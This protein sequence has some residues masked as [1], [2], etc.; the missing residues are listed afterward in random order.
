MAAVVDFVSDVVEGAVDA[1]G[2][3]VEGV[4]DVIEDVGD[5]I[6]DAGS[7]IDD[8]VLQPALDD[9]LKTVATI[10]AVA[11]GQ[12]HLI[13]YINAASVAIKGGDLEDIGKAY[14]ISTVAQGAG[15]FVAAEA[16]QMAAGVEY[17]V[18]AGS[19]QAAMLAAQEAGMNTAIDF[20]AT[21]GGSA[22]GAAAGAALSGGDPVTA[23]LLGGTS[24]AIGG[25]V[26]YGAEEVLGTDIAQ[27][28]LGKIGTNVASSAAKA[29]IMPEVA[30][31]LID[32]PNRGLTQIA[33]S[34]GISGRPASTTGGS[35]AG[36]YEMKK[37]INDEGG[38]IYVSFKDGEPQQAIPPGYREEK[39]GEMNIA[40]TT[41]PK[42]E[43]TAP[44]DMAA[45]KGG[46][47]S[48]KRKPVVKSDKG[49]AKR[50]K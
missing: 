34:G 42:L 9:P 36:S 1:V 44:Y 16:A 12:V 8:N 25:G 28:T 4:G 40:S 6:S 43:P 2:D 13:P 19:Q 47:A 27:S 22:G 48:K 30:G 29:A 18:S 10:A 32:Q 33:S 49:L 17:G 31:A 14:V 15:K 24:G 11:T 38:V 3:V 7:W 23:A 39:I 37:Y 5:A 20:A 41:T 45:A 26:R 46:L 50:K 35:S 21:T